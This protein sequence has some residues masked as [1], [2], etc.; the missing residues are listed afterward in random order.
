VSD[1]LYDGGRLRGLMVV[2]NHAALWLDLR[3]SHTAGV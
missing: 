3:T 2:D 1:T